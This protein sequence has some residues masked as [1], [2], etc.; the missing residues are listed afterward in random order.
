MAFEIASETCLYFK[1]DLW[2]LAGARYVPGPVAGAEQLVETHTR[3]LAARL[4][5]RPIEALTDDWPEQ[6]PQVSV[7]PEPSRRSI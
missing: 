6:I 7:A 3:Q 4:P 2:G 1:F 5:V